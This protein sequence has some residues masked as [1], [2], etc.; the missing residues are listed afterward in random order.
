MKYIFGPVN[1]RRFGIS[2]GIDL[3]PDKKSCNFD[4]IYCELEGAKPV[5]HIANPPKVDDVISEVKEYLNKHQN[6][7][8]ITITSNGEPTLYKDL[9]MLVRELNKIKDSKK[10]L[11][12]SNGSTICDKNIQKIL[13]D[14]DIVKLSLD[15]VTQ[16]C[17]KK[18]DRPLKGIEID[19]ISNCMVDFSKTFKNELIIEVLLVKDINDNKE[20]MIKI[21]DTL[22]KIKPARV[23]IGTIDRPP[24]Y[25]VQPVTQEKINELSK[26]L[27][28][29]PVSIIYK[30]KP[31][32]KEDFSQEEILQLLTHRPQSRFDIENFF[33]EKSKKI[34]EKLLNDRVIFEKDIAGITFYIKNH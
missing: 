24:A 29:L 10:L 5:S 3:S 22:H 9:D 11:I 12:L 23:D 16:K 19:K 8:V 21:N 17:F 15:C 4:C 26:Y 27:T 14:I 28:N 30:N 1:S 7:D 18:I 20:E 6:I 32:K 33:S 34:F 2:L 25:K 13:N 31:S